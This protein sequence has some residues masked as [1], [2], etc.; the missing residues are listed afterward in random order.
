[1]EHLPGN[2]PSDHLNVNRSE[3]LF[4][5][6][7]RPACTS[8]WVVRKMYPLKSD[9]SSKH[10]CLSGNDLYQL[11]SAD[12]ICTGGESFTLSILEALTRRTTN[13]S[14]TG[15]G[16]TLSNGSVLD[17]TNP[18]SRRP[19]VT[20]FPHSTQ[21]AAVLLQ[22]SLGLGAQGLQAVDGILDLR[23]VRRLGRRVAACDTSTPSFG[24]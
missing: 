18:G 22:L 14:T 11:L 9:K 15:L 1:M 4:F 23:G 24:A 12:L 19:P 5:K 20:S 7:I 21:G 2:D 16:M 13:T 8:C 17:S 3:V 10:L 6:R